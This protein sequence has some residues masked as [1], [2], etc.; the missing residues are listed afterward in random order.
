MAEK[1]I[2]HVAPR[3]GRPSGTITLWQ[4]EIYKN[5][6]PYELQH[7]HYCT[8]RAID[9][10]NEHAGKAPWMFS[11]NYSHPHHPYS[12]PP[13]LLQKYIGRIKSLPLPISADNGRVTSFHERARNESYDGTKPGARFRSGKLCSTGPLILPY[14]K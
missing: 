12:P 1:R 2:P 14:A 13:E 5:R 7:T 8:E 3:E 11:V 6:G 10:I 4:Y 9:F